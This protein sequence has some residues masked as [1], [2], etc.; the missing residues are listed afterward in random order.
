MKKTIE[1]ELKFE[2]SDKKEVESFL[3]GLTS[4]G[5][6]GVYDVYLDT[7]EGD[8]Y[9]RGIFIRIRNKKGLDFKFNVADFEDLNA[10][11]DHGHCDELT[12]SLPLKPHSASSFNKVCRL[13]SLKEIMRSDLN[14][15]KKVNSL[16]KSVVIDKLRKVY[17]DEVYEY[18]YD[19]VKDLGTYLEIEVNAKKGDD[20]KKIKQEMKKHLE[21]LNLKR[22]STGY[23]ELYMR[24]YNFDLY[25]K[26]R[27]L[28]TE[29]Y[30]KYRK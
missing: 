18:S 2:V 27:Y 28:L 19:T 30:E 1:V 6:K 8:L 20:V 24:K 29:D 23:N 5:E 15:F 25:L 22:I 21:G 3:Q 12:F 11:S 4:V 9:Q 13:L 26:G 17:R 16:K 7:Q 14:E 10:Y